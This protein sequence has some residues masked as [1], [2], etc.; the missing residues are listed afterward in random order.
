MNMF[1]GNILVSIINFF[2]GLAEALL[3]LRVI[4]RLFKAN[5]ANSFVH[6]IYQTSG[7]LMD[8]FRGIFRATATIANGY[9]LDINALFAM[10]MY[11]IIG[12]LL[13]ALLGWVPAPVARDRRWGWGRGDTT[14]TKVIRK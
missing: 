4:F 5:G 7:T 13:A 1:T 2:V 3:G 11:A 9:V 14:R 12:Y 6:W 10:L 8:P